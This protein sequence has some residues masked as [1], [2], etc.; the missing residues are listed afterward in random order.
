[1][2]QEKIYHLGIKALIQNNQG[3]ILI[4]RRAGKDFWDVPGGRVQTGEQVLE[5]LTREVME[6][7][8]LTDLHTIKPQTMALT[9]VNIQLED[10][11]TA[12]LILW[13]HSCSVLNPIVNLSAEHSEFKWV[14]WPV[15]QTY[16]RFFGT[17]AH[18]VLPE[19]HA[20]AQKTNST[21]AH[22]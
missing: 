3:E 8:G 15:A 4:L 10:G 12:G 18:I 5:T 2:D 1:M 19:M 13:Y 9:P 14:S 6:E 17:A 16:V 22:L 7:T 11:T 20:H 21:S